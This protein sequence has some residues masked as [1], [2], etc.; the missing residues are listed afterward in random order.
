MQLGRLPHALVEVVEPRRVDQL[1]RLGLQSKA[2]V[3]LDDE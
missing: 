1:K 2:E 3:G